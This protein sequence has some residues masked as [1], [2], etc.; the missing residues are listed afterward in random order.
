MLTQLMLTQCF[1]CHQVFLCGTTRLQVCRQCW[2][3]DS[4]EHSQVFR[5]AVQWKLTQCQQC[6][7]IFIY[8]GDR[9]RKCNRCLSSTPCRVARAEEQLQRAFH[10]YL[11][12][13]VGSPVF[14][15]TIF[16]VRS[17]IDCF[18]DNANWIKPAD[19]IVT[20]ALVLSRNYFC[21]PIPSSLVPPFPHTPTCARI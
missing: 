15:P 11:V 21:I 18:V 19:K 17:A 16:K 8:K 13:T 20:K 4:N 2:F 14:S 9:P 5:V 6:G 3:T 7:T 1:V 10:A 12:R